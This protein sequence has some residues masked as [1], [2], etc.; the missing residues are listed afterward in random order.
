MKMIGLTVERLCSW[1]ST[2][3]VVL[4]SRREMLRWGVRVLRGG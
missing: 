3:D 1:G 2:E 4:T